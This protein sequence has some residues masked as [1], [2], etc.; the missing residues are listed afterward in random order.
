[1]RTG[2]L[3]NFKI[4][5]TYTCVLLLVVGVFFTPI[6]SVGQILNAERF[7][8]EVDS[9][10][11]V[12][13]NFD[14]G[15]HGIKQKFLIH[16][17]HGRFNV[18]AK[19]KQSDLMLVLSNYVLVSEGQQLVNKGFSHLRYRL[20]PNQKITPEFFT[21]YQWDGIRGMEKRYLVGS[22]LRYK[23]FESPDGMINCGTGLMYENEAWNYSGSI[24][25]EYDHVDTLVNVEYLKF[26]LYF[27]AYHKLTPH[28]TGG[29]K[30]YLQ[31]LPNFDGQNRFAGV[32]N[33]DY[34]FND[35]FSFSVSYDWFY[36]NKPIAPIPNLY[37]SINGQLV[38]H[39]GKQDSHGGH[40]EHEEDE[41]D[42]EHEHFDHGEHHGDQNSDKNKSKES[43]KKEH[44]GD[45]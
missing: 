29:F 19:V 18:T 37:Y 22:N 30:C 44:S 25:E 1:M 39:F 16:K 11:K 13:G 20:A 3:R 6:C 45:H 42:E 32:A 36:D 2:L 17:I 15:Y 27:G 23:L 10:H 43:N 8:E 5:K 7:Y 9:L 35:R 34:E 28:I 14:V 21:Q 24:L 38:F 41:E 33:L 31:G 4:P 40:H 26:N 12:I